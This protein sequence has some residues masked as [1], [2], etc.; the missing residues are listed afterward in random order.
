M[1]ITS[2]LDYEV[3]LA[4]RACPVHFALR[5]EAPHLGQA[6]PRPAAFCLVLDR[7]G[8]M[9]GPPLAKAK[10]AA[11]LAV[12]NLRP[13]DHFGLVVFDDEAQV[14]IPFQPA[15]QKE[16]FLRLIEG[17]QTGG[18]TNL[19]GGWMLGRDELK[20][21]AEG[22]SRRLLLLSDG[23]L[24]RGVTDPTAVRQVVAAGLEKQNVRTS[25][26]GFGENYD[27]DLMTNLAQATGGQFYDADSPE[28]F[29][30]I[31]EAELEGLQKITVQ[32]LR[33]RLR[34]LDFCESLQPLG[35]YPAVERPEGWVEYS[36]GDLISDE[37]R[38]ACFGLNVLPLPWV[39]GRP[40]VSLEG[41]R[42]LE[43]EVL[44]D[45]IGESEITSHTV[46]QVVRIQATQNPDEVRQKAEVI[47][48]VAMQRAGKVIDEVTRLMDAGN[49]AAAVAALR[50]T[51]DSL[52]SYGPDA[53]VG[54]AVQQLEA[55]LGRIE[56]GE[57]SLRERKLSKYRSHSYRKMSS[58]ELWSGSEPPPSFKQPPTTP[59]DPQGLAPGSDKV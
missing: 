8:S 41:E 48:W 17:I 15:K 19:T 6:R 49:L 12:R 40:V 33:V 53:P 21:A 37:D 31:F 51:I 25:C 4:N 47:P 1:K 5:F 32:N 11:L 43:I 34:R 38:V 26:L 16:A 54:E 27:E 23:L 18:C 10:A 45:E 22:A 57:W 44:Y 7:S 36:L 56:G 42:L 55:L 39:A 9:E 13:E 30:A 50:G 20:K 29:P 28:K 24:N 46:D 2:H 58:K 35:N 14:R 52:K 3:I 59:P